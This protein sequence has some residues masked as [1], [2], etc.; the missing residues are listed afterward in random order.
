MKLIRIE[1]RG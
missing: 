1:P